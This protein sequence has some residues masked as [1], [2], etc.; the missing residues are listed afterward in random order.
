M[1]VSIIR[2]WQTGHWRP[3]IPSLVM[4]EIGIG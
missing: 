2:R 1:F 3:L 4:L